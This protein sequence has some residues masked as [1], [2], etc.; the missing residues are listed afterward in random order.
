VPKAKDPKKVAAGKARAA[1][2]LRNA[3]GQLQSN[4]FKEEVE[5]IATS[6]GANPRGVTDLQRYYEQNE[7]VIDK[8]LGTG[9]TSQNRYSIK[10]I[11]SVVQK[12]SKKV[13]IEE[14]DEQAETSPEYISYKMA[15]F[16]QYCY[17]NRNCTGVAWKKSRKGTGEP[18]VK[19]PDVDFEDVDEMDDIEFIEYCAEFGVIV[20]ISDLS[21]VKDKNKRE[22]RTT[23]RDNKLNNAK[24]IKRDTSPRKRKR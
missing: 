10:T 17:T 18:I 9:I 24:R 19:I 8:Y 15:E 7:N 13:Y 16:E 11:K 3:S 4:S 22:Q 12:T 20:W 5:K 14:N 1:K 21:K 6:A 2:S 23:A